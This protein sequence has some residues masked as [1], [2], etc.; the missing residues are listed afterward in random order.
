MKQKRK[1]GLEDTEKN[2]CSS[3]L[4]DISEYISKQGNT[5]KD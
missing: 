2:S 1:M 3:M 4:A 5:G